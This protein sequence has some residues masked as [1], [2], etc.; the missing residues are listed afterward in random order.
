[1]LPVNFQVNMHLRP[2]QWPVMVWDHAVSG[3][4][5]NPPDKKWTVKLTSNL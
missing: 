2:L 4:G 1:M 3:A 5:L